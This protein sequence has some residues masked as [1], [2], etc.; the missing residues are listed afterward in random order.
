MPEILFAELTYVVIRAA[1]EVHRILG[2]GFL[3]AV[4]Q[5]ALAYELTMR[6]ISFAQQV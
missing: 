5:T 6:G 2:G 3:E 1:I 4:H